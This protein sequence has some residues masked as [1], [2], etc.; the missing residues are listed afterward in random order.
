MFRKKIIEN[1]TYIVT[2]INEFFLHS[3][4]KNTFY[5]MNTHLLK[6]NV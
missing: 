5:R 3:T 4:F 2:D 6:P 1:Y